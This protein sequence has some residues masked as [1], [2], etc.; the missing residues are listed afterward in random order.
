MNI[1][2]QKGFTLIELLVVIAIISILS[3]V[4]LASLNSGRIKARSAVIASE[5][6][7]IE[8]AFLASAASQNWP[9]E[10][11][12]EGQAFG[13]LPAV[14]NSPTLSW[15]VDNGY[16]ENIPSTINPGSFGLG[17]YDYDNE[18]GP[19]ARFVSCPGTPLTTA[20]AVNIIIRNVNSDDDLEIVNELDSIF[21]GG[22]GFN[23]GKVVIFLS[24]G[25][26]LLLF[27]LDDN[28]N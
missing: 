27:T 15:L 16:L 23:C 1:K 2:G 18:G 19:T 21:D 22:D 9:S 14:V 26:N 25:N 17:R 3:A 7:Q 24:G 11:P 12:I 5:L 6:N 4:A 20:P 8:R 28:L 13:S 10:W